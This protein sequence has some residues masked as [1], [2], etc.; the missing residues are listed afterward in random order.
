MGSNARGGTGPFPPSF[1]EA[2][3]GRLWTQFRV[4]QVLADRYGI[5]RQ[6]MD[7]Y[8]LES[9]RRAAES[10]DN[11][12][13]E[14]EAVAVP[15]KAEDGSLTG[16]FLRSDEGI[17]RSSTIEALAGA[18]AGPELGARDGARHHGGQRVA[19]H[20]RRG[21]HAHRRPF[22]RRGAGPARSGPASPTSPWR[23]RTP[24][25]CSRHRC[26]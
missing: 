12:H 26:R 3:D 15:I 14:R 7:A 9:H 21:R 11:G 23:P 4:S 10:W 18:A 25:S 22:G 2:I 24:P 19:D 8:A 6:E 5:T 1:M 13:F 16:E 17:R 20:R